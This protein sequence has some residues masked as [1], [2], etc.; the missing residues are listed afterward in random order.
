MDYP[1]R[2]SG[3]RTAFAILLALLVS[4]CASVGEGQL[5]RKQYAQLEAGLRSHITT[6]AS[7]EFEGRRP[8]TRGETLTLDY[9][10]NEF[11]RIGFESGTND[12]GHPWLAPVTLVTSKPRD[13]HVTMVVG[14]RKVELPNDQMLFYSDSRLQRVEGAEIVFAGTSSSNLS[15]AEVKGRVVLLQWSEDDPAAERRLFDMGATALVNVVDDPRVLD[16]V[17]VRNER[18]RYTLVGEEDGTIH[19]YATEDA[20]EAGLGKS[21]W[22][23]LRAA[24][25]G[26][27][28]GPQVLKARINI[29]TNS[30][31]RELRTNNFIAKLPGRV[32]NSGA[33]LLMGHWDH[34]GICRGEGEA[35]RICNGA[36]DNASGI[37][38]LI[39][40][41]RR[42]AATG[43]YDRDIYVLGTTSEELGLLG[44]KAFVESPSIPLDSIIAAFN[45]DTV[46]I[47]PNGV[48]V[49][50]IGQGQTSLD[51]V[52]ISTLHRLKRKLAPK[53]LADRFSRRQD[54]WVL[55]NRDVPAIT[56]SNMMADEG[57]LNEFM[58]STYHRPND[59]ARNLVLGGAIDD[60]LL[61]EVLV[62]RLASVKDY[63]GPGEQSH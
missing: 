12:P 42:L 7:D 32:P 39:E 27:N 59:D 25:E 17:R 8:G 53:E 20:I 62:K 52:V 28:F 24:A 5:S 18:E 54:G 29:E 3:A 31:V 40:L 23:G 13:Q 2:A 30:Q 1:L 46:A 63:P 56:L 36:V 37:A 19:A 35:D 58:N 60:L 22:D 50:Y 51:P 49:G 57:I 47:A 43:P 15:E 9:L 41:S 34:L 4:A 38:V 11:T 55:L 14:R 33:I 6:L 10:R 61:H 48:T 21:V 44:A 16:L 26:A 45:F